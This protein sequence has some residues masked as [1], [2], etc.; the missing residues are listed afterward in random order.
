MRGYQLFCCRYVPVRDSD[1]DDFT[2]QH[3]SSVELPHMKYSRVSGTTIPESQY[4]AIEHFT[5]QWP[6]ELMQQI[7]SRSNHYAATGFGISLGLTV[8]ELYR[9]MVWFILLIVF[10]WYG[11]EYKRHRGFLRKKDH[12]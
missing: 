11:T 7:V 4:S 5:H 12:V 9:F 8:P 10:N 1:F 2:W 3:V 6:T